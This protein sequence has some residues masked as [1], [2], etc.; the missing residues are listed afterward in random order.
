VLV[1]TPV[2]VTIATLASDDVQVTDDV[3]S[4]VVPSLNSARAVNCVEPPCSRLVAAAD[5]LSDVAIALVIVKVAIPICPPK[6]AVI[7]AVPGSSPMAW[8]IVAG[9]L[10]MV[11]T[12]AG[13][14]VHRTDVVRS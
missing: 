5:T 11:A 10:L 7:V 6:S 12:D 13:E 3:T 2:G 14:D 8:P 4:L 9:R 1:A